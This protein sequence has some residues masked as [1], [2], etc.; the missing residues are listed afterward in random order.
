MIYEKARAFMPEI[1]RTFEETL[2]FHNTVIQHKIPFITEEMPTL[3]LNITTKNRVLAALLAKEKQLSMSLNKSGAISDL[4]VIVAEFNI[5]FSD[6]PNRLDGIHSLLS[7]NNPDGVYQ[8]TNL[9]TEIVNG[10]DCQYVLPVL[11]DKLPTGMNI[12][13]MEILLLSQS[14]K[15]FKL[16]VQMECQQL[17]I[18]AADA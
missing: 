7:A 12:S 9:L 14:A 11:R 13:Q 6:L 2:S 15:L 16:I 18:T 10:V 8:I 4:Q 5:C 3:E 1:Q 17:S